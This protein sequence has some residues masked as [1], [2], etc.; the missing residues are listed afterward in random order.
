MAGSGAV[1]E[2][3]SLTSAEQ[4]VFDRDL[5]R[6]ANGFS[7][8][9]RDI[10]S[11]FS[12]D[13]DTYLWAASIAKKQFQ[14]PFNGS[15]ALG[16][17]TFGMQVIRSVT[18]NGTQ[19]WLVSQ[20]SSGW[21]SKSWNVNLATSTGT[22]TNTFNRVVLAIPRIVNYGITPKV[23]EVRWTV[24]PT[25]Y[26]VQPIDWEKATNLFAAKNLATVFVS[27]NGT[28]TTDFNVEATGT[29]GT[30]AFGLAFATADWLQLET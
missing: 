8:L 3:E 29:D 4:L 25:T 18:I 21:Q 5:R 1:L 20:A 27:K 6:L 11:F 19:T 22:V 16:S 12:E 9:S 7:S 2:F 30:A 24:G 28:F 17:G 13:R 23:K 15:L 14:V 26:A 10:Q